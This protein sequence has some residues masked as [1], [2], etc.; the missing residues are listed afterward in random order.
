MTI[1]AN[2]YKEDRITERIKSFKVTIG[3]PTATDCDYYF[4][5]AANANEQSIELVGLFPAYNRGISLMLACTETCGFTM[6]WDYGTAAGG[7][8]LAAGGGNSNLGDVHEKDIVAEA[9]SAA[10]SIFLNATPNIDWDSLNA[11]RW[12]FYFVYFDY[13]EVE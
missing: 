3:N 13:T 8:E 7:A 5:S 10:R 11:G 12:T 6:T 1:R 4:T 9:T 2:Y